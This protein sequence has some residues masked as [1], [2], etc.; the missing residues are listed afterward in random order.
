MISYSEFEKN[1]Q[2]VFR[3]LIN[4][5]QLTFNTVWEGH[6]TLSN[7]NCLLKFIYDLGEV[8]CGIKHPDEPNGNPGF[9]T[10][11]V[12][13]FLF[14]EEE[15][16]LGELNSPQIQLAKNYLVLN[17]K[18][19]G[20]FEGNFYWEKDYVN[21]SLE[22]KKMTKFMW[23]NMDI[24]NPIYEKFSKGDGSWISDLKEY[25]RENNLSL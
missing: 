9:G 19:R 24:N 6:Y 18:L 14:P 23:E 20:V 10:L 5:Y 22:V 16:D 17:G 4:A 11:A 25:L 21:W 13:R 8:T 7:N 2:M 12:Y 15:I 1:I 3:K